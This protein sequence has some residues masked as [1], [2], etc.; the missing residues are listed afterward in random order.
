MRTPTQHFYGVALLVVLGACSPDR[1]EPVNEYLTAFLADRTNHTV[2]IGDEEEFASDPAFGQVFGGRL[3]AGGERLAVIDRYPP[4]LRIFDSFGE[5]L[6][7]SFPE[8]RGP[9][10][11]RGL[12]SIAVLGDTALIL[13]HSD[14]RKSIVDLQGRLIR[15]FRTEGPRPLAMVE[16][17]NDG[18]LLYRPLRL[19]P[20]TT[21]YLQH[22]PSVDRRG[23]ETADP[24]LRESGYPSRISQGVTIYGLVPAVDGALGRH[25]FGREAQVLRWRCG[26]E[27]V[28]AA[29]VPGLAVTQPVVP[30]EDHTV[31]VVV[32]HMERAPAGMGLLGDTIVLADRF[33]SMDPDIPSRTE[34]TLLGGNEADAVA[35]FLVEGEYVILDSRPGVGLLLAA[36]TWSPQVFLVAPDRL[37]EAFRM[38]AHQDI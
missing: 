7:A 35:T 31:S 11:A 12:F 13:G 28:Q 5:R 32:R 27:Q 18:L 14:G 26:T 10:E 29:P 3:V 30:G 8:G 25:F 33:R 36:P 1:P 19:N 21:S 2:W 38:A 20:N 6:A 9:G 22:A 4:R 34:F 15:E 24:L 37:H 17:C 23:F 16:A